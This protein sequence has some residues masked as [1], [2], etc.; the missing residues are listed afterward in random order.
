M[1]VLTEVSSTKA[2]RSRWLAMKGWRFAIQMR[3][4][5]ATS[6]RFC[7]RAC[8]SFFVRQPEPAQRPPDCA[9]VD[10]D[11]M[12]LGQVRD[13]FIERDLALGRDPG[14][15]PVGQTRQLA[16]PAAVALPS[17]RQ[18]SSFATQLDQLVH[19]LRRHPEV[20]RRITVPV[21]FIDVCDNARS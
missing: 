12:C 6:L 16:V 10:V 18:R 9:A 8:R 13:Q 1:L 11:T 15:D 21:A 17:R 4:R 2:I 3:L 14:V 20:P 7:S 5:L 19:E